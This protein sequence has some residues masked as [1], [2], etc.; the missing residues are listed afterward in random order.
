MREQRVALAWSV[1][2]HQIFQLFVYPSAMIREDSLAQWV[3]MLA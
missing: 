2:G 3:V 1:A